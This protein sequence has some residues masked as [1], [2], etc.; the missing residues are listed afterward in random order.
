MGSKAGGLLVVRVEGIARGGDHASEDSTD[1]RWDMDLSAHYAR[2]QECRRVRLSRHRQMSSTVAWG[3]LGPTYR[4]LVAPGLS[5]LPYGG[6][7]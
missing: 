5:G 2:S 3:E 6:A 4:T 1:V 7:L